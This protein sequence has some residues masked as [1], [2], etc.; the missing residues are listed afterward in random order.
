MTGGKTVFKSFWMQN[1]N[2]SDISTQNSKCDII[3]N[4]QEKKDSD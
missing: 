4:Y 2:E 3:L 1:E